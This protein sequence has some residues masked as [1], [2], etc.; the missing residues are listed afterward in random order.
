MAIGYNKYIVK[1][2]YKEKKKNGMIHAE[3]DCI[4]KLKPIKDKSKNLVKIDICVVRFLHDKSLAISR[5]CFNCLQEM[6]LLAMKKGYKIVNV[7]YSDDDKKIVKMKYSHLKNDHNQHF[8][9]W[10]RNLENY[11]NYM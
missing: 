10:N 3:I 4:R 2:S 9:V 8:S 5:P 11:N 6:N 1:N 7:Y